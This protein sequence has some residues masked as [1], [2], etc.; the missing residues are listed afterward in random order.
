M[1]LAIVP[2][3]LCLLSPLAVRADDET[4]PPPPPEA[5]G[6]PGNIGPSRGW[7]VWHKYDPA[8]REVEVSR[9]PPVE[10]WKAKVL[11]WCTTYRYQS[12]GALPEELLPG[13][14]VNVFFNPDGKTKWG[15]VVHFQ[16]ELSQMRGHNH[17][18]QVREVEPGDRWFRASLWMGNEKKLSDDVWS[19]WIDID[20]EKWIGGKRVETF[21]LKVDDH[22]WMTWVWQNG[23]RVVKRIVDAES[24]ETLKK[25]QEAR[26]RWRIIDEGIPGQ[27]KTFSDPNFKL[28]LYS[29]YWSQARQLKPSQRVDL[30]AHFLNDSNTVVEKGTLE[31]VKFG[32]TYGSGP[33]DVSVK[34]ERYQDALSVSHGNRPPVSYSIRAVPTKD[35][36]IVRM[37]VFD[38]MKLAWPINKEKLAQDH[39]PAWTAA[40][41]K[42]SDEALRARVAAILPELQAAAHRSARNWCLRNESVY[43]VARGTMEMRPGGPDWL[44]DLTGNEPMTVF[45]RT[46]VIDLFDKRIAPKSGQR[47][48]AVDDGYLT[49]FKDL[50]DVEYLELASTA[51]TNE[52][53]TTVGTLKSL[54]RLSVTLTDV[55]GAGMAHLSGLTNLKRLTVAS[56]KCTGEGF[57]ALKPLTKLENLNFHSCLVN[58]AGLAEVGTLSSLER[59]E[60]VHTKFTDVGAKHLAGL[61]NLRRLQIGSR[62]ATGASVEF[63]KAL[64]IRELDL[65]DGQASDL[66]LEH[67]S[68]LSSIRILRVYGPVT[69]SGV[70]HLARLEKLEQL[71]LS[72]APVTDEGLKSLHTLKRLTNVDLTGCKVSDDAVAALKA[73]VPGVV[74]KR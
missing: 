69:D 25:Q 64:P 41:E 28:L 48:N 71:V 1:R 73:A 21:P 50:P 35:E 51:V 2:L 11:P 56:S 44:R 74:V 5:F 57:A 34:L 61:T 45:D 39:I 29:T 38:A 47:N 59:L 3:L 26:T 40:I 23:Q 31:E 18:W 13:E 10:T 52:G 49:Q 14:R 4:I 42:I 8:T 15:Y 36:L 67:A 63:I 62:E 17:A 55:D 60:I 22:L 32:G 33:T 53:M 72:H 66:G 65:H 70:A 43:P 68:A 46:A 12:Y 7:Y 19:F 9:D 58:D 30:V 27:L 37:L 6:Y 16:D 24:C 20:C 54:Q